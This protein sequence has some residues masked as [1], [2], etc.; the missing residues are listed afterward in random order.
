MFRA[1]LISSH[2]SS[3]NQRDFLFGKINEQQVPYPFGTSIINM[4][5]LSLLIFTQWIILFVL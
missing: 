1:F 2:F 4:L 5:N 3:L